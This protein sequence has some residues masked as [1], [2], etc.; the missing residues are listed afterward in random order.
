[1][2]VI[3]YQEDHFEALFSYWKKLGEQVPY[4]FPVSPEKWRECLLDDKLENERLFPFQEVFVALEKGKVIGFIQYGQPA[5]AWDENGQLCCN[6]QIG[7]LRHFYFDEDRF[8]AAHLL[9]A[10]GES[11]MQ[12]FEIRHAFYHIFGMSC[13]A[14]HGKL[15]HSLE[16]V[17][18]FLRGNGY[19]VEHENV[20]YSLELTECDPPCQDGLQL[21]P[22]PIVE[23]GIRNYEICLRDNLIGTLQIRFLDELT[24][25]A[26]TDIA[27]LTWIGIRQEFRGQGCGTRVL[28]RL[29]AD[30]HGEHY[31][32]LHLDTANTNR[33]AQHFYERFGF[34]NRGITR[35]YIKT[36]N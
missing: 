16:H 33:V 30:L 11:Y 9:F 15:H 13:N 14:H 25:G 5:F 20:Y 7:V 8:D 23:P 28:Q 1:M 18:R 17:D 34:E 12:Q 2:E 22:K 3:K 6:P 24:G 19:R 32:Q 31:R 29:A 36:A 21:V 35:C 26:T 10:A 27:C 4:F